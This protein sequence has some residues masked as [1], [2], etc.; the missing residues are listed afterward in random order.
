[1]N[2]PWRVPPATFGAHAANRVAS[3]AN[4]TLIA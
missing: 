1:M 2:T 3:P 4:A